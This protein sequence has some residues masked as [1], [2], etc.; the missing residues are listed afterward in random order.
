MTLTKKLWIGIMILAALSP[1]GLILPDRFKAGAAWGEWGR[2]EIQKMTGYVPRGFAKL[3][4]L[5]KAPMPDYAFKGWGEKGMT[6]LSFATILSAILGIVLVA[7]ITL[8]LGKKLS[9][10]ND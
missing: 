10:K 5:W 8:L 2:E 7:A 1:I 9:S 4:E 3:S 6:H